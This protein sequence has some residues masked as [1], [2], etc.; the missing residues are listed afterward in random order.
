MGVHAYKT[1]LKKLNEA[2]RYSRQREDAAA[3]AFATLA[4]SGQIDDAAASEKALLFAGWKPNAVYTAGQLRQHG[5]R[6]YRCV[7]AHTSQA[8]WEPGAAAALWSAISDPAEKWPEWVQPQDAHDSY[9]QGAQVSHNGRR[10]VSGC[11]GNVWEPGAAG[12]GSGIWAEAA[13]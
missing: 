7:Q 2:K 10:W 5:G 8:G 3:I 1:S 13:E 9:A 4:E 6:L 11:G 12:V